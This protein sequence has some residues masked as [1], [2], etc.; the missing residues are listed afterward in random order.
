MDLIFVNWDMATALMMFIR[1]KALYYGQ[2]IVLGAVAFLGLFSFIMNAYLLT[3]GVAV[4]H[5]P[6]SGVRGKSPKS[7][8]NSGFITFI[9]KRAQ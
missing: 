7:F 5:N 3:R 9:R 2:N 1:V 8:N 4:V 6:Q